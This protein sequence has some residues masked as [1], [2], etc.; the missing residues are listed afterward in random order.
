M[1]NKEKEMSNSTMVNIPTAIEQ[2][3]SDQLAARK[4]RNSENVAF[5]STLLSEIASVG[6]KQNRESTDA[7]AIDVVKKFLK[8]VNESISHFQKYQDDVSV[9]EKLET[10][11][12]EKALLE[13]LL[14]KMLTAEEIVEIVISKYK[15][16]GIVKMGDVMKELKKDY[17]SSVD[18]AIASKAIKQALE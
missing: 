4:A 1:M 15:A 13:K 6:K 12:K 7:E 11:Q 18:G 5:Y 2:I 3:K 14:P 8:G 9:K 10:A 16:M 17:G